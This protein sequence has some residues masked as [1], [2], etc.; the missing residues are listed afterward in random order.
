MI[1]FFQINCPAGIA[2]G[3]DFGWLEGAFEEKVQAAYL[4]GELLFDVAFAPTLRAAC[5]QS[6][7]APL[8]FNPASLWEGDPGIGT[9][10]D[11]A[12]ATRASVRPRF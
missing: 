3:I 11:R 10:P 12:G 2:T 8:R 5:R 6:I 9:I 1:S 4:A 7:F